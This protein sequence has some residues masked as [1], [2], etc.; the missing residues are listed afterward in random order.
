[1]VTKEEEAYSN[2]VEVVD[3]GILGIRRRTST[4]EQELQVW[5]KKNIPSKHDELT[6]QVM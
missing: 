3:K 6:A 1:M 2:S 4:L 5:D